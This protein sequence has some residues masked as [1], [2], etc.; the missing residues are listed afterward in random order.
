MANYRFVGKTH[1]YVSLPYLIAT[2]RRRH[3]LLA[4]DEVPEAA[5]FEWLAEVPAECGSCAQSDLID[6]DIASV[7]GLCGGGCAGDYCE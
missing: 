6:T 5:V 4:P 2:C 7:G 3:F 1:R